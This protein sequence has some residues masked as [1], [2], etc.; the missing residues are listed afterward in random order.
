LQKTTRLGS[1]AL[2]QRNREQQKKKKKKNIKRHTQKKTQQKKQNQK[3]RVDLTASRTQPTGEIA[4]DENLRLKSKKKG[5][6][7]SNEIH[8]TAL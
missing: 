3:L 5:Y 2:F 4:A 6:K 7:P 1:G 8:S